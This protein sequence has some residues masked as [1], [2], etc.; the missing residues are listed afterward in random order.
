[1]QGRHKRG[2]KR[3]LR[4]RGGASR[5]REAFIYILFALALGFVV[6]IVGTSGQ[7]GNQTARHP[8]M[9][10]IVSNNSITGAAY[11]GVYVY[12]TN[13]APSDF[14]NLNNVVSGNRISNAE[15]GI[16]I[17]RSAHT[18]INSNS[19]SFVSTGIREEKDSDYSLLSG[20]LIHDY[21]TADIV[22]SGKHSLKQ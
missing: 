15:V 14:Q 7:G 9:G 21:K 1:M 18:L 13:Y 4:R 22:L 10:N 5:S 11:A 2:L 20:N 16:A 12:Q 17:G 6:G 8:A 19:I 3:S